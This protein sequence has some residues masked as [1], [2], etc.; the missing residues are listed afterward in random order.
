[1]EVV[2]VPSSLIK[3]VVKG[4]GSP[5]SPFMVPRTPAAKA[6]ELLTKIK[7][8]NRERRVQNMNRAFPDVYPY[9]QMLFIDARF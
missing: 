8:M 7:K 2:P 3:I 1:L 6:T 4:S 5:S 9:G